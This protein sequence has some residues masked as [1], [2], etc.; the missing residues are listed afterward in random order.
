MEYIQGVPIY[1]KLIGENREGGDFKTVDEQDMVHC[2]T[3]TV[4]AFIIPNQEPYFFCLPHHLTGVEYRAWAL[5]EIT[6]TLA[7]HDGTEVILVGEPA[8]WFFVA[9]TGRF[10]GH[11]PDEA[12]VTAALTARNV[13]KTLADIDEGFRVAWEAVQA[14]GLYIRPWLGTTKLDEHG[15]PVFDDPCYEYELELPAESSAID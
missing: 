3:D 4:C 7:Y 2:L 8:D 13:L 6:R 15:H 11:H 10:F 12:T 14:R 9:V 1:G 5:T